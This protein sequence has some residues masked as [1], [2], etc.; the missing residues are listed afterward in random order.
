M[1]VLKTFLLLSFFL[2]LIYSCG[3]NVEFRGESE[4]D[5]SGLD[6]ILADLFSD[7][8]ESLG[9]FTVED[10]D[11]CA[12][13]GMEAVPREDFVITR[14]LLTFDPQVKALARF[15]EKTKIY[16]DDLVDRTALVLNSGFDVS[17]FGFISQSMDSN[18][19]LVYKDVIKE[20]SKKLADLDYQYTKKTDEKTKVSAETKSVYY[21]C[22]SVSGEEAA[23][24]CDT[25]VIKQLKAYLMEDKRDCKMALETIEKLSKTKCVDL[26]TWLETYSKYCK[27][28]SELSCKEREDKFIFFIESGACESAGIELREISKVCPD[29]TVVNHQKRYDEECKA[30]PACSVSEVSFEFTDTMVG[31]ETSSCSGACAYGHT[32][33]VDYSVA[34]LVTGTENVETYI[35]G[36]QFK[37]TPLLEM[38]DVL[39]MEVAQG[40]VTITFKCPDSIDP[41][42]SMTLAYK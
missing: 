18:T 20:A 40:A 25:T 15:E 23:L 26:D 29:E 1:K 30:A 19:K 9:E 14:T 2:G 31:T 12:E 4:F 21:I 17:T 22:F 8:L 27:E 7:P 41:E 38:T 33:Q 24:P 39:V 10:P 34:V 32:R 6:A 37:P 42:I 3:S 16:K 13:Y 5:E 35:D 28:A 11:L 36:V